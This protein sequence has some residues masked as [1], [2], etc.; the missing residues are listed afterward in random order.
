MNSGRVEE[1][2]KQNSLLFDKEN[3][4]EIKMERNLLNWRRKQQMNKYIDWNDKIIQFLK[5]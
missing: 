3:D 4:V 1:S 2:I 5:R